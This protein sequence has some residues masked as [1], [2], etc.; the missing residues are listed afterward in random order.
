MPPLYRWSTALLPAAGLPGS[1]RM[2]RALAAA[3]LPPPAGRRWARGLHWTD[4]QPTAAA[5]STPIQYHPNPIPQRT[6]MCRWSPSSSAEALAGGPRE[7]GPRQRCQRQPGPEAAGSGPLRDAAR[8]A[9]PAP[10]SDTG[11][12]TGSRG[13]CKDSRGTARRQR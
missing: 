7:A 8:A 3:R 6:W 4:F 12:D 13:T 1:A 10:R 2:S 11:T 5:S 9:R